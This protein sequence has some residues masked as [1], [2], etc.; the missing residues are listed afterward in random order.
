M[1]QKITR[2]IF[3]DIDRIVVWT[4]GG[5]IADGQV[6]EYLLRDKWHHI[7][8]NDPYQPWARMTKEQQ[9]KKLVDDW[10]D[11]FMKTTE[12]ETKGHTLYVTDV[13]RND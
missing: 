10:N 9:E 2:R 8:G 12:I 3:K 5:F 6:F 13:D 11:D 1:N 7:Q 4:K